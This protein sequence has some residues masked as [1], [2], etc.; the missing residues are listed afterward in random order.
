MDEDVLWRHI[1]D[2]RRRTAD[3][4]EELTPDQWDAPSLCDGWTVGHVAAHLTLQQQHVGDIL[5]L[6]AH[7]PRMLRS[8][9]L[10]R[11]IH[12]S[13]VIQMAALGTEDVIGRIRGMVGSRRHNVFVT[14]LETLT[15]ILVH[16]QDIAV[17][18]GAELETAIPAARIAA[19]R[20]WATRSSWMGRVYRRVPLDG[21]LLRATDT[22]WAVGDGR[23]V[24]GPVEDLLLL[25]TGR[26]TALDRL[27]GP[28]TDSLRRALSP[29]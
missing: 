21:Y 13:A 25:L 9:T 1:D 20:V 18:V 12:D 19:S 7:H 22:D 16:G 24:A 23:E 15:D 11:A 14:P 27:T 4:L 6:I 3:L 8:I 29:A 2:Q 5:S 10:N 17:P 26:R 28:G